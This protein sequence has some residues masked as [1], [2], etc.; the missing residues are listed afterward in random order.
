MSP[1]HWQGRIR[2]VLSV[3][4]AL[5]AAAAAPAHAAAPPLLSHDRSPVRIDSSYGNGHFGSWQVDQ[6]GLPAFR[7]A[8]D[9]ATDPRAK[10]PEIYRRTDPTDAWHQVGNDHLHANAYNHGYLELW[11]QDRLMQWANRYDAANRHY[12]GGYGYLNVGGKV[13][14]TLYADRPKGSDSER[15]FGVGYYRKRLGAEGVSVDEHTFAPFGDDPLLVDEVTIAN[16]GDAPRK[17]SWFEYWDV[18]PYN[19][20]TQH[21]IGLQAP[22]YDAASRTLSV[23]QLTAPEGDTKP[24]SIFAAALSG[25][26]DGFDTSVASFFGAGTRAAPTAVSADKLAGTIAP[27]SPS[28]APSHQLFAFRAQLELA[29][30]Q[31]VTLRYAYG[32]AHADKIAGLVQ[33]Y[34]DAQHPFESSE[35]QWADWVPKASL[36]ADRRW[37]AREIEWDAYLLRSASVYEEE[38]GAHNITQGGYYQYDT[39]ENLGYRSWLHYLLPMTY[40]E[41]ALAREILRYSIKWQPPGAAADQQEPYG[42][43]PLC[44]R[45]DLGTSNDLDFWL[46]L[47]AGEYGLGTRD[48]K[49]F[50]EQL[51]YYHSPQTATAW[52]H[53]KEAFAHQ[54]TLRG[55]HGG[56]VMGTTGDWNDF[57]TELEQMSESNLVTAQLAYAYPKL[58]E[59]A[60]LRGDKEFAAELRK[61]GAEDLATIRGQWTGRWYTRGWS[62]A[63]QVGT[64]AIFEEPQPWAIL[65]GAPSPQQ[66]ATLAAN[67]H[68]F[69]DGYGAP[70]GP[71]RYGTAQVPSRH[72][73]GVTELGPEARGVALLPE[74]ALQQLPDA[75]LTGASQWPGGIWFDLNGQLTWAYA[76]LDGT[77][78]GARGLAWDEYTRNTLARHAELYP[79]HWQGT[80]SVDD[81]CHAFY[82]NH[83]ESCGTGLSQTY[84]GQITEQPTWMVMDAIRLA[85]VTPTGRGFDI[86]PHLPFARFSL[87]L[88]QIGVAAERSRL[89]GY[90][91]P[92]RDGSMELD[93][94]PPPGADAATLVT[95]A[96][97]RR[98]RHSLA[99]TAARF[100]VPGAAGKRTDWALTWEK[101]KLP[102]ARRCKDR[103]RFS[104]KLHHGPGTRVVRVAVFVNGRRVARRHGRNIRRVTVARLPRGRFTLRIVSTLSNGSRLVSTRRYSGCRKGRPTTRAHHHR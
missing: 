31:S 50:D 61:A 68:R 104:F 37:V 38:C 94:H 42:T 9:E 73:P 19:Q 97:G 74:P 64:G 67:I 49:F 101:P 47:A 86:A 78:P 34:R 79:D 89:R 41:P 87:R 2:A 18:D 20:A 92:L 6:F 45:F 4:C 62:G 28:G 32:M 102:A 29:P 36:G 24:L 30:G 46:L 10:Q 58:A 17:V 8:L 23:Q 53:I 1:M 52:Q 100:R 12:A 26:V 51:P 56:Y 57:S 77:L 39:G 98:V 43:G 88:P 22:A 69:L 35:R 95:W 33:K 66:S 83:P 81:V 11:S 82:G 76:S 96:N 99:G 48:T 16:T 27:P 84:S 85:G 75:S 3:A 60:D 21:Q 93:V 40:A 65:A 72:D 13:L 15:D 54:E 55:P 25:P 91:T 14:S 103:R 71:A 80:I 63:N 5:V 59:L 7:Y 70:G 44:T 90:V